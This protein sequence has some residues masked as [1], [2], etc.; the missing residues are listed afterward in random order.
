MSNKFRNI[1]APPGT[2]SYNGPPTDVKVKITLIEFNEEEF[3]EKEFYDLDDCLGHVKD[4]LTK[5]INV[6]VQS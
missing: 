1:G 2:L 5:W 3:I 4:D 6:E